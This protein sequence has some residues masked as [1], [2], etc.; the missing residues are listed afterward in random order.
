MKYK[1]YLEQKLIEYINI[2]SNVPIFNKLIIKYNNDINM[3]IHKSLR[4]IYILNRSFCNFNVNSN[5]NYYDE[6]TDIIQYNKKIENNRIYKIEIV[7]RLINMVNIFGIEFIDYLEI[8][9]KK[10]SELYEMNI[11]KLCQ[12]YVH[13]I[14]RIFKFISILISINTIHMFSCE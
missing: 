7:N 3:L 9:K 1:I 13:I 10:I 11:L 12:Y 14:D 8:P 2:I 6:L 4:K 5:K